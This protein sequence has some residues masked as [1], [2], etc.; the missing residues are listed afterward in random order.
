MQRGRLCARSTAHCRSLIRNRTAGRNARSLIYARPPGQRTGPASHT[1]Q[2][3]RKKKKKQKKRGGHAG[4]CGD[5]SNGEDQSNATPV[6]Q[7]GRGTNPRFSRLP[8]WWR[9]FWTWTCPI[10]RYQNT[11]PSMPLA[12]ACPIRALFMRPVSGPS[13]PPFLTCKQPCMGDL[14][15]GMQSPLVDL[16]L[17]YSTSFCQV[18]TS[19]QYNYNVLIVLETQ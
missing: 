12:S 15:T 18:M 5:A 17:G 13:T 6:Q 4:P 9:R 7:G 14:F 19:S 16:D 2:R 8:E 11:R 10:P 1:I 3:E